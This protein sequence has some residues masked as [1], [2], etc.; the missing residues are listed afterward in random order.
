MLVGRC[1]VRVRDRKERDS[2]HALKKKMKSHLKSSLI[3]LGYNIVC[4]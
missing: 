4:A 3:D 2:K 1:C